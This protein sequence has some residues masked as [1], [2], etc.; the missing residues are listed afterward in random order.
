MDTDPDRGGKKKHTDPDTQ[1]WI[2]G[3]TFYLVAEFVMIGGVHQR[4]GGSA[5]SSRR[6]AR[7]RS[8]STA[9]PAPPS[10]PRIA[11]CVDSAR[12]RIICGK[13][14]PDPYQSEKLGP[15]PY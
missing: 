15:D 3:N 10:V 11:R 5:S 13:L 1:H 12:I 6:R 8:G 14:D 4:T 9:S 7:R 2:L